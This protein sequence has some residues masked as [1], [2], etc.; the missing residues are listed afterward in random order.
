MNYLTS[1]IKSQLMLEATGAK[2]ITPPDHVCELAAKQWDEYGR[3]GCPAEWPAMLRWA[4]D[5]DRS[6]KT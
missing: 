1:A 4:D 2:I 6:Y 5:L 3:T